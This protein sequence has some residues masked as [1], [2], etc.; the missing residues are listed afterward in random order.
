[1][2]AEIA[3]G[4]VDTFSPS[5]GRL[6]FIVWQCRTKNVVFLIIGHRNS[7]NAP[8]NIIIVPTIYALTLQ[9]WHQ[10]NHL[11]AEVST[12]VTRHVVIS[13]RAT[14]PVKM[15]SYRH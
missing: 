2:T 8:S 1:M 15:A 6:H 7:G 11:E 4:S 13:R 14:N 3:M 12:G 5:A 9:C 10:G